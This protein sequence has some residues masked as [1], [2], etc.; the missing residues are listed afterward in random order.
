M[1][2]AIGQ[3]VLTVTIA[4]SVIVFIGFIALL[5]HIARNSAVFIFNNCIISE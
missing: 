3:E 4:V 2:A 5:I 1:L